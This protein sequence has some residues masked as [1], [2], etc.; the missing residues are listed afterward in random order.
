[1]SVA[2][3]SLDLALILLVG[4]AFA[5]AGLALQRWLLPD[6]HGAPARLVAAVLGVATF[7]VACQLLGAAG[8]FD[9]VPLVAVSLAV[10]L[11]ALA[12]RRRVG[13]AALIDHGGWLVVVAFLAVAVVAGEWTARTSDALAHG[14]PNTDTLWYHMPVAARIAQEGSIALLAQTQPDPLTPFYPASAELFHAA[15]IVLTGHDALSP[16][17]NLGWLG[18]A[19]AAA[20][21][22]GRPFGAAP[23]SLLGAAVVLGSPLMTYSQPGDAS[24]DIAVIA[25]FLSA[26]AIVVQ[27]P[28][29]PRVLALAAAPAGLALGMKVSTI[30]PVVAL[31]V[32]L[33]VVAPSGGRRQVLLAW[34]VAL[35]ALAG[36]WYVRNLIAAG[37]PL[38]AVDVGI[39]PAAYSDPALQN[40]GTGFDTTLAHLLGES[41]ALEFIQA[42]FEADFGV[43]WGLVL[44]LA[45]LG[46]VGG[47]LAR[48]E[49]GLRALG[50]AGILAVGAW[51][52]TPQSGSLF[53]VNVRHVV[54]AVVL[55]F[56]LLP[57]I[58]ILRSP[59]RRLGCAAALGAAFVSVEVSADWQPVE[60]TVWLAATAVAVLA[61]VGFV[62]L[63]RHGGGRFGAVAAGV[64]GLALATSL[65]FVERDY[66]RNRYADPNTGLLTGAVDGR[67]LAQVFAWARGVHDSTIALSGTLLQ[68]PLMGV[69]VSNRVRYLH[70]TTAGGRVVRAIATCE[71]WREELLELEPDYLVI[72]PV[73]FPLTEATAPRAEVRW[74]RSLPGV[75]QIADHGS[76]VFVFRVSDSP[77]SGGCGPSGR[78][79]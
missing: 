76:G 26:A 68:Y 71:S 16:L 29:S 5:A 42:G 2:E 9:A 79:I 69:D 56:A 53:W 11:A 20:W 27:D 4:V 22:I 55:G 44:A 57:L 46:L 40:A 24:N 18:L 12:A 66:L 60:T 75:S 19:F 77:A 52:I 38:P 62:A 45:G 17:L 59:R 67:P 6:W 7:V 43:W 73:K 49:P 41:G 32:A 13:A 34:V 15:A 74:T 28:R 64:A 39:F 31:F 72:T 48:D 21:C 8:I 47:L 65:Y 23:L 1:M 70:D 25:L 33:L 78:G 10:G 37:S 50:I 36:V 35:P 30:A 54:P 61:A 63:R 14:M 3:Y 58:P 51:F